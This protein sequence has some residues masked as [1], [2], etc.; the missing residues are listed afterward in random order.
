MIVP[1]VEREL[2]VRVRAL[3]FGMPALRGSDLIGADAAAEGAGTLQQAPGALSL[4]WLVNAAPEVLVPRGNRRGYWVE[5]SR[6]SLTS[7]VATRAAPQVSPNRVSQC[8]G[9]PGLAH[10]H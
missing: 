1:S 8:K 4:A 6:A 2:Y 10:E 9:W 3:D 7:I 5:P